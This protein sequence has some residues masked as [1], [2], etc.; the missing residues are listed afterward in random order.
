VVERLDALHAQ[1][2]AAFRELLR[3]VVQ[4]DRDQVW[5]EDG[6]RDLAHWLSLRYGISLWKA[7]RWIA[8]THALEGLPRIAHALATGE[9]GADKALEL[10][11]LAA[12]EDEGP[13]LR[14]ARGVS[15]AAIQDRADLAEGRRLKEAREADRTRSCSLWY[16]DEGRRFALHAELPA[17]DGAVVE[18][19]M[20]R[21]AG[22]LPVLPGE[23]DPYYAEARRADALVALASARVGEDPDPDRATVVVHLTEGALLAG[24]PRP[25]SRTAR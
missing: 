20:D 16:F 1:A 2:S 9:L 17:A 24:R 21:V 18:R 19:A 23:E 13:L 3:G 4:A 8:C 25:G 10:T 15:A 12:P 5:R 22:S 14:W 7:R 11:R 6:A